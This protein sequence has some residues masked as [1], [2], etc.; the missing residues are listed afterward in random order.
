MNGK[1]LKPLNEGREPSEL[2]EIWHR[3]MEVHGAYQLP[4][5]W[6]SYVEGLRIDKKIHEN[7]PQRRQRTQELVNELFEM[8]EEE[9][10]I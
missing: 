8:L 1:L 5:F 2:N 10:R 6:D 7:R 3:H 4:M 9:G